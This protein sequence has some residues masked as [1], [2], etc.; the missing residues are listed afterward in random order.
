MGGLQTGGGQFLTQMLGCGI[1]VFC[2]VRGWIAFSSILPLSKTFQA[3]GV[4]EV[5]DGVQQLT[6]TQMYP[7]QCVVSLIG[8]R[9][10][11]LLRRWTAEVM[12]REVYPQV[13]VGGSEAGDYRKGW[14]QRLCRCV[15]QEGQCC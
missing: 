13:R 15:V 12:R 5:V 7:P 3:Q 10:V 4:R 8:R 11:L 14:D 6:M 2:R 1:Q 9:P